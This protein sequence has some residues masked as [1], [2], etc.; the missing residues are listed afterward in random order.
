MSYEIYKIIH[1]LGIGLVT[2]SL[3][4]ILIARGN[5]ILKND[6]NCRKLIG[7]THGLGLLFLLVSGFGMLARLGFTSGLPSWAWIKLI[8]WFT[9][10]GLI[11]IFY[12]AN[13]NILPYWLIQALLLLSAAIVVMYK[14]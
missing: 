10:G 1:I 2:M 14:P 8:I 7:I 12:R 9:F 13:K 11:A 5:G 4:G 3:G 6:N